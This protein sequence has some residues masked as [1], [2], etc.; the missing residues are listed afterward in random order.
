MYTSILTRKRSSGIELFRSSL[1]F[2]DSLVLHCPRALSRPIPWANTSRALFVQQ[3]AKFRN[4]DALHNGRKMLSGAPDVRG[5]T[6]ST[7]RSNSDTSTTVP[8]PNQTI[9]ENGDYL[10]ESGYELLDYEDPFNDEFFEYGV[11]KF[12]AQP[13]FA[14][15]IQRVSNFN[16]GAPTDHMTFS[17]F[18]AFWRDKFEVMRLELAQSRES[19]R[20]ITDP[21]LRKLEIEILDD[22]VKKECPCCLKFVKAPI[23]IRAR[24]GI[25][26]DIFLTALGD[27][28][29]GE[30]VKSEDLRLSDGHQGMLIPKDWNYLLSEED[31]WM[32]GREYDA[33]RIWLYCSDK[34]VPHDQSASAFAKV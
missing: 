12:F 27:Q 22:V 28:L 3:S 30:D 9:T 10:P 32:K 25:T 26:H 24:Q 23:V 31:V 34:V 21:L 19:E 1:R 16:K 8:D 7:H 4:I 11:Y 17:E 5:L 18:K 33:M 13:L 29:Y 2:A 6:M 20:Y 15:I 14:S